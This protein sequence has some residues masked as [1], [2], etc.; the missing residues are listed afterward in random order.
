MA[1]CSSSILRPRSSMPVVALSSVPSS[2]CLVS[3]FCLRSTTLALAFLKTNSQ[4]QTSSPTIAQTRIS[5][6]IP[7]FM[8]FSPLRTRRRRARPRASREAVLLHLDRGDLGLL[9]QRGD[10]GVGADHHLDLELAHRFAFALE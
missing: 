3:V 5:S 7:N 8:A 1:F 10:V 9:G 4:E 2:F 6:R